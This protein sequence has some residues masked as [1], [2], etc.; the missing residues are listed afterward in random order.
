MPTF[1]SLTLLTF[2]SFIYKHHI[3]T[4]MIEELN[5]LK[6][7]F[8]IFNNRPDLVYLDT[9]A[10]SQTPQAV[11]DELEQMYVTHYSNVHRGVYSLTGQ[12]TKKFE[13]TRKTVQSFINA[14]H[15]HEIVFSS[16]CT[17]GIN[18]VASSI[19]EP[20]LQPGDVIILSILEHHSNI[21]PWQMVAAN[22]GA[23]IKWI[24][25][26]DQGVLNQQQYKQHLKEGNVKAVALTGQSNVLGVK[27][28]L[29]TM[30]AQAHEHSV[31]VLIDAAQLAL[32]APIDVQ[33]L[34]C[35][36]LVAS[37]H[38][39]YGPTGV[40]ILYIAEKHHKHIK[41]TVGGGN[42]IS[43]VTSNGF[44]LADM[45]ARLEPG[46][47]PFVQ[48][49]GFGAALN[50]MQEHNFSS[51]EVHEQIL[52]KH[53]YSQLNQIEEVTIMSPASSADNYGSISFTVAGVHAHDLTDLLGQQGICLRAGHHCAQPLHDRFGITASSRISF[54]IYNTVDDINK[55]VE[56]MKEIIK[57]FRI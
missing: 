11:L 27:P 23:I 22:T 33:E 19:I 40:G 8:P 45:P 1:S 32:H 12:S 6:A 53:A 31:F 29:Q 48:I 39:L 54:G 44:T 2:F 42:M 18:T 41:P 25:C 35:D 20:Q 28:P 7:H 51:W 4:L 10:S 38:K 24:D 5:T 21:V 49:V 30:I 26:D 55:C 50:W 13:S 43:E 37:S 15:N 3:L 16:G 56:V 52:I 34:D 17:N 46:T 36:A 9:A 14:K 57:G 47:P